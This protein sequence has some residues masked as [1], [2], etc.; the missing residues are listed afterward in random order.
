MREAAFPQN[1]GLGV[2]SAHP[3]VRL[4][5]ETTMSAVLPTRMHPISINSAVKLI[6]EKWDDLTLTLCL[7]ST[8]C[9]AND[10]DCIPTPPLYKN[11]EYCLIS[12][13]SYASTQTITSAF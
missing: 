3:P 6:N 13:S 5:S 2:M 8:I 10:Q 1:R 11:F 12:M 9:L 4:W 7:K